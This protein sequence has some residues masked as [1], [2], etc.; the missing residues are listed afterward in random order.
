MVTVRSALGSLWRCWDRPSHGLTARGGSIARNDASTRPLDRMRTCHFS[1]CPTGR[2][3]AAKLRGGS[4]VIA[5]AVAATLPATISNAQTPDE[6]DPTTGNPC[7]VEP[8]PEQGAAPKDDKE[9]TE[10]LDRC[11]GVLQPPPTAD[12]EIEEPPPDTGKTPVIPPGELP[13]QQP[14]PEGRE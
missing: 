9:L 2:R 1:L 10:K 5:M 7:L 4:L 3:T 14:E 11:N 12:R 6:S 8:N 13:E